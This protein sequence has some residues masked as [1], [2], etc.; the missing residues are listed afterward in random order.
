MQPTAIR[1]ALCARRTRS[2]TNGRNEPRE[3][4]KRRRPRLGALDDTGG[5]LGLVGGARGR[6]AA[7]LLLRTWRPIPSQQ[8]SN[9]NRLTAARNT[10][11]DQHVP[12]P[13]SRPPTPAFRQASS[14]RCSPLPCAL[15]IS[16]G[17]A[18]IEATAVRVTKRP[19]KRG[20]RSHTHLGARK[21][22]ARRVHGPGRRPSPCTPPW[23]MQPCHARVHGTLCMSGRMTRP[24]G[25]RCRT[26]GRTGSCCETRH[27]R[28]TC[29]SKPFAEIDRNGGRK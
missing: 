6:A 21:R 23:S 5:L 24:G 13:P 8:H 11:R 1:P 17:W 4:C 14:S 9:P 27:T 28:C 10:A 16:T 18:R 19:L 12:A 20:L 22:A 25:C 7:L 26:A 29:W 15:R 3:L 2:N